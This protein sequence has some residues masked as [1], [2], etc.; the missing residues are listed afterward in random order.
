MSSNISFTKLDT[1]LSTLFSLCGVV[2]GM[3]L[4]DYVMNGTE[5]MILWMEGMDWRVVNP[6]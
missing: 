3:I 1:S 6:W 4:W 2:F 5:D